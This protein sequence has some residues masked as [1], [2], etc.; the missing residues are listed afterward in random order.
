MNCRSMSHMKF[1]NLRM[2]PNTAAGAGS[3]L[4]TYMHVS[5]YAYAHMYTCACKI[6]PG[7]FI[8]A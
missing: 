8:S 6:T 2:R 3:K 7:F 1:V 4:N 5:I